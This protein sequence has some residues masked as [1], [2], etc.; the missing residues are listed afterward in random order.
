MGSEHIRLLKFVKLY[1]QGIRRFIQ[2]LLQ[3][4]QIGFCRAVQKELQQQFFAGFTG[5]EGVEQLLK[6]WTVYLFNYVIVREG[7]PIKQFNG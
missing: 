6:C 7:A 5:D 1:P 2:L 3:M 4:A